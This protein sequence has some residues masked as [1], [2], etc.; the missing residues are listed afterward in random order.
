MAKIAQ[1][2]I[3][4]SVGEPQKEKRRNDLIK[5]SIL[6]ISVFAILGILLLLFYLTSNVWFSVILTGVIA[7]GTFLIFI[8][9]WI[10]KLKIK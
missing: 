7:I 5:G 10:Y 1:K 6:A 8:K 2:K 3:V 4:R 9:I